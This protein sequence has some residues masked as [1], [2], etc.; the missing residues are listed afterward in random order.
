MCRAQ[1]QQSKG[2]AW[3]ACRVCHAGVVRLRGAG[4]ECLHLHAPGPLPRRQRVPPHPPAA[5]PASAHGSTLHQAAHAHGPTRF[6]RPGQALDSAPGPMERERREGGAVPMKR[7]KEGDGSHPPATLAPPPHSHSGPKREA[8]RA[9]LAWRFW[10]AGCAARG[11]A[12]L[13]WVR[14]GAGWV[15]MLRRGSISTKQDTCLY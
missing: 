11:P 3:R 9:R 14:I 10:W 7:E 15:L 6:A 4:L 12:G 5:G 1:G 2:G 8:A 13:Q